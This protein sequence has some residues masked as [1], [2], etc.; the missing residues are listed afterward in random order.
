MSSV[1]EPERPS[2]ANDSK[3]AAK[4]SRGKLR[5]FFEYEGTTR[6]EA[7]AKEAL[8]ESEDKLRALFES[9]GEGI[10]ITDLS[11]TIMDVNDSVLRMFGHSKR[12]E[13]IGRNGADFI[14]ES[15]L[16]KVAAALTEA[17]KKGHSGT[18]EYTALDVNGKEFSS[19][20]SV[21][22]LRDGS[23]DPIGMIF[24]QRDVSER[25]QMEEALRQSEEKL[26]LMFNSTSD[27]LIVTDQGL[28]ITEVNDAAPRLF[29]Y[30]SKEELI[31][32]SAIEFM[33]AQK[34]S[35][36]DEEAEE[37]DGEAA[38]EME[39]TII[40]PDGTKISTEFSVS[41][42]RDS[43]DSTIG[44]VGI[45]RDVTERKRAQDKLKKAV[46]DLERSNAELQQFAYVASHDL[47][48]PLRMISSYT[49]LL[50]RRYQGKIDKDADEF[51]EY[52][53]DG[54]NRMQDLIN[55]LLSYSRVGTRGNP[56]EPTYLDQLLDQALKNLEVA[57]ED[58][59]AKL[60]RDPL[61]KLEVDGIQLTQLLQNLIGNAM[62]FRGEQSPEVHISAKEQEEDWLFSVKD[63]G[64]GIEP[65][66]KD[67]IF[68][69]FQ[70]L[71]GRGEYPGTGIGLA[72]CKRIIERHGGQIWVESE[73]GEGA[74]FF[75]TLPKERS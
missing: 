15:D 53:V 1:K 67:R 7:R 5:S 9:I 18:L 11:G 74:T 54:A 48:E 38:K 34:V 72:V 10:V 13:L 36:P 43:S 61:P 51:I 42:M 75:F 8:R 23:G 49:Q 58:S 70:R 25:K 37:E 63:N 27:G 40:T 55:A 28:T 29:G 60:T 22:M 62:K 12:Q 33:T 31:G 71:H 19:E 4:R 66:Y 35:A 17:L 14:S 44:F 68:V 41:Q 57:M 32:R 21:S 47:Q 45:A 46:T 50:A 64:I 52:A 24:V 56:F 26:R 30:A 59:K 3:P 39:H 20:A 16:D 2:T 69:I 6:Q 65:Q 73:L